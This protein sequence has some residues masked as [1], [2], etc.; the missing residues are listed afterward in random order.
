MVCEKTGLLKFL[1]QRL[2]KR[3]YDEV[4]HHAAELLHLLL[5]A[6]T[7]NQRRLGNMQVGRPLPSLS[8]HSLIQSVSQLELSKGRQEPEAVAVAV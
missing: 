5:H 6:D 2:M 3:R 1:M 4:K 7:E 8:A